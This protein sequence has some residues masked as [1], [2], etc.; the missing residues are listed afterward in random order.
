MLYLK[1]SAA[2]WVSGRQGNIPLAEWESYSDSS[3]H[4]ILALIIVTG[5]RTHA[6]AQAMPL[7]RRSHLFHA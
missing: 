1:E 7:L 3:A 4:P 2:A 6:L 5:P